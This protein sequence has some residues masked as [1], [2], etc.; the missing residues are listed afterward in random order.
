MILQRLLA[1]TP[2]QSGCPGSVLVDIPKDIQFA[3]GIYRAHQALT[4]MRSYPKLK[5]DTTAI[6]HAV[7][8]LAEEKCP[9]IYSGGGVISSGLEAAKLLRDL[10][11]LGDFPITSTLMGLGAYP[12]SDKDWLGMLEMHGIYEA[13]L[14]V[15]VM[16]CWLLVR[17]LMIVYHWGGLMRLHL[18]RVIILIFIILVS[19]RS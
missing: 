17:G 10:V 14:A 5:G 15:I 19:I 4:F 3:S 2:A 11:R 18:M 7:S 9:V 8:R 16:L 13:N 1:F 6:E 12:A